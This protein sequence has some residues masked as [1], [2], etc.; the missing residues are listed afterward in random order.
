MFRDKSNLRAL[1]TAGLLGFGLGLGA[2]VPADVQAQAE[3]VPAK[4]ADTV[5]VPDRFLRRWDPVTLF[6]SRSRGP[7]GGGPEDHPEQHVEMQ[8]HHPGAWNWLDG[9]TL[10]FRPAEPWPPLARFSWRFD[11]REQQL[12]TLFNPPTRTLP[13]DGASGLDPIETITLT[14]PE[15]VDAAAL[16][17]MLAIEL[18]PL[19]GLGAEPSRWLGA[20]DFDIKV[21][22]RASRSEQASYVV[23]FRQPVAEGTHVALHLRL[24]LDDSVEQAFRTL[25]FATATP[26]SV[27]RAGCGGQYLALTRDGVS[28]NKEQ[29]LRCSAHQHSVDLTFSARPQTIDPIQARN[30]VR[31]TP[32]VEGLSFQNVGNSLAVSGQFQADTLYRVNVQPT[33]LQDERGRPLRLEGPSELYLFFPRQPEF[34]RWEIGQGIVERLG[35]QMVPLTGRGMQRLDLRIHKIDPLNRSFWPFPDDPIAIDESARP[36]GPG[37]RPD[38]H[39]DAYRYISPGELARQLQAIGSPGVSTL[40]ELPLKAEGN[41]A[42]FGLD[43]APWLEQLSGGQAPGTYL[44]GLRRL[45]SG[46]ERSW[47]RVQATDLSLS[48]IDESDRVRFVVSSL[49]SGTPVAGANIRVEGARGTDW[50]TLLEATSDAEGQYTW[51]APGHDW[52]SGGAVRRIVVSK[53]EDHLVLDPSRPP[54]VYR[55]GHWAP[56]YDTW[57][58]W[59][60]ENLGGREPPATRLCHLFTER[61]VYKPED[62]VHIRGFLRRSHAGT[63]EAVRGNGTLVVSGPGDKEWRYPVE[64]TGG[65]NLYRAFTEEKLPTGEF[66]AHYE[67]R[68]GRCGEVRFRKEA[69]RLPRFEVNLNGPRNATLDAPFKVL[70][71]AKYYAGGRVAEQPVRWRVTQFPYNWTPKQREGFVYSTDARFGG[72][73]AFRSTTQVQSEGRTDAEGFAELSLDPTIEPT[74]QPRRYVVEATVT[75]ADDQ[76]VSSTQEVLALPPFVL[77]MKLPRYLPEATAI[78]PEIL[79]AGPDGELLA[80]QTITLRLLHR[81]WHSRLQASDFSNGQAKYMTDVVDEPILEQTLVS[82]EVP[83]TPQLPIAEAGVYLVEIT[84]QDKLGRS[85]LLRLDLFAGGTRA[86][87]WSK[88]PSPVFRVATDKPRYAPGETAQLVLESPFQRARALAIVEEP[89]GHN[90]YQWLTVENGSATFAL[91]VRREHLP[92]LPVHFLLIR[93]RLDEKPRL[94]QDA[95]DLGKPATLAATAWVQ[96]SPDHN[97]VTVTLDHPDK[98]QPGDTVEVGVDLRDHTGQPLAGEVTLWLVD[99]AVLAL[100]HEAPLDPLPHFIHDRGTRVAIRDTR[101]LAVGFLPFQEQPGGDA[102]LA[103]RRAAMAPELLDKVTVRKNFS[104]VPFYQPAIPVDASGRSSVKVKLPDNLTNFR[105][106]AVVASGADRFG[107]ASG[108]LSVRL[109]VIVQPSLPR[110]VRPGDM[111][112]ATAI[113]RIVEGGGGAGRASIRVD[114]LTLNGSAEQPFA[115]DPARPQRVDYEMT[116]PT[117]E[118]DA[119][120]RPQREQVEVTL[121]V[122]RSED[123]ARD[124]FSVTL[125]IRPDRRPVIER[126][127]TTLA[128]GEVLELPAVSGPVRP[129]TLSRSLLLSDQPALVRMAAGLDYLMEYPYGCTEQRVSRA[130]V[131]LASQKLDALLAESSD[132]TERSRVVNETLAWI[133]GVVGDN[134]LAGYWPGSNG[135]VSL[136]AWAVQ[137][138][139]EARAAGFTVDNALLERMTRALGQALRSDYPHLVSGAQYAERTW[140]LT[141]LAADGQFDAG[142]AAE[143]SRRAEYLDLESVAQVQRVLAASEAAEPKSLEALDERLWGGLVFRLYNGEP[144]YGGLQETALATTAEILPSETRTL[145][146]V[147]RTVVA[148]GGGDGERRQL[149]LNA[150]TTLGQG[151][152]WGSTNA[153]AAALLSLAEF[154]NSGNGTPVQSTEL[155][156]GEQVETLTVGGETPMLAV[157]RTDPAAVQVTAAADAATPLVVRSETRYLPAADGSQVEALAQGFV[158]RREL[159]RIADAPDTPPERLKLEA[160]GLELGF[161]VGQVVEEHIELVNPEDRHYVA[162]VA[163]IAAGMEPLNPALATAPPEAKPDGQ[164]TLEPSYTHYGDDQMAWYFDALPKGTYHFYFRTRATI[165]GSYVQPAAYAE[166]MYREAVYG[167]SVG[168]KVAIKAGE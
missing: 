3:A 13:A 54:Q 55:N 42:R 95:L 80:G 17:Q 101:N 121:G 136:T 11:G 94:E 130:R 43:L 122:E 154:L 49:R 163:P 91:P 118:Y 131:Q 19:P 157:N 127:L 16:A 66:S 86:V 69:Y 119:E 143:L 99:Q 92:R 137:F 48:T 125:P 158:V 40:V 147:L 36:P 25:H 32:A 139:V 133:D 89:E 21:M 144:I 70:L 31:F 124:A 6:F 103:E 44:V 98:A 114:G 38:P 168:A 106:R 52:R 120:G 102:A 9:R 35:P 160:P 161:G 110:F 107:H 57:L 81:Q 58:Q 166:M 26:F 96:V 152:G 76:T 93:G 134:G 65:G 100:G 162:V 12:A 45:D 112:T 8:P 67:D 167:N 34:L 117:P 39:N 84:A 145:S 142:Y 132:D 135:Y 155:R 164:L 129:G 151:D 1:L 10:Q 104:P 126:E 60:Q 53:G 37:E 97:T 156:I 165:P 33:A 82:G 105:L 71:N 90:R 14:F 111:F 77:G 24:S 61:P 7:A 4:P 51:L 153:N 64:L 138:M 72:G 68:D 146:E 2:L 18:R 20:D 46:S 148:T 75:G 83:L 115:W 85:Q 22:P 109:P 159:L 5:M 113:G 59:T 56:A 79:V 73:E 141:A 30:L 128:A 63:L 123:K 150:I 87:T 140:A 28:Y 149:L 62:T 50:T 27:A 47:I 88:P 108:M 74:A 29:A 116:V 15:P 78:T 23:A 41:S